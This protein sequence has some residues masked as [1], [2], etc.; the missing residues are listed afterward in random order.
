MNYCATCKKIVTN[1]W[2]IINGMH[3]GCPKADEGMQAMED[4]IYETASE[5]MGEMEEER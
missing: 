2:A 1:K 4:K 3:V 5:V